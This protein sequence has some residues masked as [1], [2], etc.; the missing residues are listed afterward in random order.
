MGKNILLIDDD[1][2]VVKSLTG[3][4]A[5]KGYLIETAGNGSAG[6]DK[7][8]AGNFDVI[9]S[10]VRMPG[11]DGIKA[12]E[13]I[14][15]EMAKAKRRVNFLFITGYAE[16]DAPQHAA[17]L[18]AADFILKPFDINQFLLAVERNLQDQAK[19]QAPV[20]IPKKYDPTGR[21]QYPNEEFIYEKL[22][23]LKDTNME[24]NVYFANYLAW[25][26]EVREAALLSH[27]NFQ[28]EFKKYQFVKMITHSAYQ[29]FVQDAYFGYLLQIKM[30]SREIKKCSFV[31]VYKYFNKI[32]EAF[33]GE[34]WQR[35][36][37]SDLRSG[38]ICPIPPHVLDFVIPLCEDDS[39]NMF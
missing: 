24:G 11:G 29:R 6:F 7:A 9:I 13:K 8:L 36:A 17:D 16:D 3:L 10:D 1:H 2:L 12:A 26:G 14:K 22:V 38:K 30:T 15:A 23:T 33:I 21:W 4:L 19:V 18:G 28:E 37:F 34:G 25:Q 35:I 39:S 20:D 31:L 5:K 32:T 27:P